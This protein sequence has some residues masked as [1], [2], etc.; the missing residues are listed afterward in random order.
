MV[1]F[2]NAEVA[3]GHKQMTQAANAVV[4]I[5]IPPM[6]IIAL[7]FRH[8]PGVAEPIRSPTPQLP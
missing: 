1:P 7:G 6:A 5:T 8:V 3:F 2:A 4:R